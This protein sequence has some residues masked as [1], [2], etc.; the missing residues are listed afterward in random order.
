MSGLKINFDKSE[1]ILIG[2]DNNLAL[3]YA[4][5]FNCQIGALPM[6]YLGVPILSGRLHVADWKRLEEKLEKKLDVWQGNSLSIG[7]RS[8]LIKS[9]L[10]NTTIYHMSPL[11]KNNHSWDGEPGEGSSSR[12]GGVGL[13]RSTTW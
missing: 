10:S 7:G 3:E 8:V 4:D 13:K 9:S 1:V 6:K 11:T 5:A 2:G 12:G